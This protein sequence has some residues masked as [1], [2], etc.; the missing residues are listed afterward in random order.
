MSDRN[1]PVHD[2]IRILIADDEEA[3]CVLIKIHVEALG[4]DSI[5]AQSGQSALEILREEAVDA[6]ITD[7]DMPR[8]KGTEL[9][10]QACVLQPHLRDRF[11]FISGNNA[12]EPRN[13]PG[14]LVYK[15][16]DVSEL[17]A[18]IKEV[19]PIGKKRSMHAGC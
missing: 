1:A 7:Q 18:A 19:L 9:Y 12:Y 17:T 6:V 14:R 10:K 16:F 4:H 2:R 3:V 5:L 15:P 11:V 8:L 13:F